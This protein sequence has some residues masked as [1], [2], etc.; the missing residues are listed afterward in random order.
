M[1]KIDLYQSG[2]YVG[3]K[4]IDGLVGGNGGMLRQ[5]SGGLPQRWHF[6]GSCPVLT[7]LSAADA[8]TT[9]QKKEPDL[10]RMIEILRDSGK[11]GIV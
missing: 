9:V 8:L 2:G 1:M 3:I 10:E 6:S 7:R 4:Y 5:S 11:P